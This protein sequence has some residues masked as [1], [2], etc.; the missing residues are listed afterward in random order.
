MYF[1]H[2]SVAQ[3][4]KEGLVPH[5]TRTNL[6]SEHSFACQSI[7]TSSV[8][9]PALSSPSCGSSIEELVVAVVI[10]ACVIE[11]SGLFAD[12]AQASLD[13][14]SLFFRNL[15]GSAKHARPN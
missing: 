2:F 12:T 3:R 14:Y 11:R 13:L 9:Q 4:F 8:I 7:N 10:E 1:L 6:Q 5:A 15:T